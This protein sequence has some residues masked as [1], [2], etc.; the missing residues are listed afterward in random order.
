MNSILPVSFD[1]GTLQ[2][3]ILE[4]VAIPF[5][6]GSSWLRDQSWVSC[7]AGRFFTVWVTREAR[8]EMK[9]YELCVNKFENLNDTNPEEE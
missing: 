7:I 9:I 5:S 6:R 8:V 3:R 4:R 2:T 1:L